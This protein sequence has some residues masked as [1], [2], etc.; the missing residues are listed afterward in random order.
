MQAF[1][2]IWLSGPSCN[3]SCYEVFWIEECSSSD[4]IGRKMSMWKVW[5][6]VFDANR[7][8]WQPSVGHRKMVRWRW[9]I[10][11]FGMYPKTPGRQAKKVNLR[12][13]GRIVHSVKQTLQLWFFERASHFMNGLVRL[14]WA[15]AVV[16]GKVFVSRRT[17]VWFV[18]LLPFIIAL[19]G[20]YTCL[21]ETSFFQP[22]NVTLWL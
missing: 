4:K 15:S 22:K 16:L 3:K 10:Q 5:M 13:S 14:M 21:K 12:S 8:L 18:F 1:L 7:T 19:R 9:S 6:T 2:C 11:P 20:T 17:C